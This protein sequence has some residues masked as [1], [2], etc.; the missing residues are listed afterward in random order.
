[1]QGINSFCKVLVKGP[2]HFLSSSPDFFI[3]KVVL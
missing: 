2:S 1:L 3:Q